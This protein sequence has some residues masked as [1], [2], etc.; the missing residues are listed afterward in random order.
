MIKV[1]VTPDIIK[2]AESL[3]DFGALNGSISKGKS[4]IYGA[5]GEMVVAEYFASKGLNVDFTS[6]YDYDLIIEGYKIDVKSKQTKVIPQ[7]FYLCSISSFNTRQNCDFYFFTRVNKF[8]KWCYILG[9][10]R[11]LDFYSE[12]TFSNKGD[13]DINGWP[14]KGDCWNLKISGL[15]EFKT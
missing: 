6:T 11:K 10:K 7:D 3:Y 2:R 4:N 8:L 1:I 12:A 13:L 9:Y 15:S 14:F 5:I